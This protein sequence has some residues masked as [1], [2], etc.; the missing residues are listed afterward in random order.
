MMGLDIGPRTIED[1]IERLRTA[2]TVIWNG[3]LGFF[4]HEEFAHGTMRVGEALAN[5]SG[6]KTI[7]GGGDTAAAVGHQPWSSRFT[8]IST[9]GGATL[10]YLEGKVLPGVKALEV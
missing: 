8:H 9:G 2:K 6:A 3:P 10:E 1:F 5:L 4:E 7:I